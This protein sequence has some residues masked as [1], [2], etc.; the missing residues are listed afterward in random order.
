[1]DAKKLKK[2]LDK[3]RKKYGEMLKRLAKS[4]QANRKSDD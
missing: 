1:M 3:L 2:I 4:E